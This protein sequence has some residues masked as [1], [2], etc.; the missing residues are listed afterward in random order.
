M[1]GGQGEW[2]ME[3]CRVIRVHLRSTHIACG[4]PLACSAR[5]GRTPTRGGA[6]R[7]V[8]TYAPGTVHA[9]GDGGAAGAGG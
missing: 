3:A 2:G 8:R 4:I 9:A 5:H 1:G 7:T 6:P